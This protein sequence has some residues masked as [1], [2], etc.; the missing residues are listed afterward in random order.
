MTLS[1]GEPLYSGELALRLLRMAKE[2]GIHTCLETSGFA[3]TEQILKIAPY[4]DLFLYD[5]KCP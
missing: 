1:G 2:Q 3:P 4:V 5:I